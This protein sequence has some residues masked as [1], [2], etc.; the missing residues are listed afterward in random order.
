ME[1]RDEFTDRLLRGEI[2]EGTPT[3]EAAAVETEGAKSVLTGGAEIFWTG[4]WEDGCATDSTC[5]DIDCRRA[6]G[7]NDDDTTDGKCENWDDGEEDREVVDFVLLVMFGKR[8]EDEDAAVDNPWWIEG[9]PN[10]D[11]WRLSPS[12]FDFPSSPRL[13]TRLAATT[14]RALRTPGECRDSTLEGSNALNNPERAS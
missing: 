3:A 12:L 8:G 6:A 9:P 11:N 7:E 4:E 10:E 1:D 14:G 13:L 5:G 2:I